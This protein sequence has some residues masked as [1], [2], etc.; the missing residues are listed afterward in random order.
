MEARRSAWKLGR[1]P[2]L[3]EAVDAL[4]T[5]GV[6]DLHARATPPR[7]PSERFFEADDASRISATV[8]RVNRE[9]PTS[10]AAS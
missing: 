3:R 7:Y 8:I 5:E 2:R 1:D 9:E 6:D 4:S 10:G